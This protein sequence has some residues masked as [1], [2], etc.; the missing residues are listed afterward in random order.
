M[1]IIPDD[2]STEIPCIYYSICASRPAGIYRVHY[3]DYIQV[4][5]Q[6][7][8]ENPDFYSVVFLNNS[9]EQA[10]QGDTIMPAT[11]WNELQDESGLPE[12]DINHPSNQSLRDELDGALGEQNPNGG[13]NYLTFKLEAGQYPGTCAA[14]EFTDYF[15]PVVY[16]KIDGSDE[17][18]MIAPNEDISANRTTYSFDVPIPISGIGY[19]ERGVHTLVANHVNPSTF[20]QGGETSVVEIVQDS[21]RD[22]GLVFKDTLA[23]PEEG[24]SQFSASY[25]G[26]PSSVEGE[27]IFV[28]FE[29]KNPFSNN[30]SQAIDAPSRYFKFQLNNKEVTAP[31]DSFISE[32][33]GHDE[34]VAAFRA[35]ALQDGESFANS[36]ANVSA[37]LYGT[38]NAQGDTSNL[39]P[40]PVR[41]DELI[42]APVITQGDVSVVIENGNTSTT[43]RDEYQDTIRPQENATVSSIKNKKSKYTKK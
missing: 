29:N 36:S 40:P 38:R 11:E 4:L 39:P 35:E 28:F 1:A 20:P 2:Q 19:L 13:L 17:D 16:A 25:G 3:V 14:V 6:S 12:I 30:V 22:T 9:M 41:T 10:L 37:I 7:D 42:E 26:G 5:N 18:I 27:G 15:N 31:D 8:P 21:P 24:F 33:L 34:A 23:S 32:F 43:V